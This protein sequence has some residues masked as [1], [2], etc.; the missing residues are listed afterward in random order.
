MRRWAAL[1]TELVGFG[2]VLFVEFAHHAHV[3]GDKNDEDVYA[4]LLGEPEAE[5]EAAKLDFVELIDEENA[6]AVADGKPD[7]HE[8]ADNTKIGSPVVAI[9][10]GRSFVRHEFIQ[11]GFR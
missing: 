9:V 1:S 11:T 4:S 5:L 8:N 6:A 7:A 3:D 10:V 2:A